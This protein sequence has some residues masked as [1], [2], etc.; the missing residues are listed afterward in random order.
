M[1]FGKFLFVIAPLLV[2]GIFQ[3]VLNILWVPAESPKDDARKTKKR[4]HQED[5]VDNEVDARAYREQERR[6]ERPSRF[7]RNA[8]PERAPREDRA[9]RADRDPRDPRAEKP[10]REV[11]RDEPEFEMPGDFRL[12]EYSG[13]AS[14]S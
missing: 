8:H 1:D 5:S 10:A 13:R 12:A 4:E 7:E 11:S 3:Y 6:D 9:D 14:D 2:V